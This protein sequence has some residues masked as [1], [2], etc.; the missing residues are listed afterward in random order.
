MT[1]LPIPEPVLRFRTPGSTLIVSP[2]EADR[3]ACTSSAE[4][5]LVGW[6]DVSDVVA[7]GE[8]VT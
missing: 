3:L 4:S 5:T 8:A 6:G 1:G 7:S 2:N